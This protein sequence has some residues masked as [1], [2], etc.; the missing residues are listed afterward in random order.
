MKRF[1][2]A[3]PVAFEYRINAKVPSYL[4]LAYTFQFNKITLSNGYIEL[5]YNSKKESFYF[6]IQSSDTFITLCLYKELFAY[7]HSFNSAD[8][9]SKYRLNK[10][11]LSKV[12]SWDLEDKSQYELALQL[13]KGYKITKKQFE[14]IK[15]VETMEYKYLFQ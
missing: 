10:D 6:S 13:F 9:W 7:L 8:Y 11:L 5:N 1:L 14:I 15:R 3:V 12:W 4:K 2:N